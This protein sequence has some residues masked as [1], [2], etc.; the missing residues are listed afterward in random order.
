VRVRI[1]R[2]RKEIENKYIDS[3]NYC[4]ENKEIEGERHYNA[5]HLSVT[6]LT[7]ICERFETFVLTAN[8]YLT[9]NGN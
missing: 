1:H 9:F 8:K 5:C 6:N 3:I 2:A 4:Y 7:T